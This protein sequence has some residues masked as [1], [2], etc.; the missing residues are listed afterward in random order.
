VL[1]GTKQLRVAGHKAV[2]CCRVQSSS[3]S[4][5]FPQSCTKLT[6]TCTRTGSVAGHEEALVAAMSPTP[7]AWSKPSNGETDV[8]GSVSTNA[9]QNVSKTPTTG[10]EN[11]PVDDVVTAV[12]LSDVLCL[13]GLSGSGMSATAATVELVKDSQDVVVRYVCVCVCVCVCVSKPFVKN[14]Q[15][16]CSKEVYA[17]KY[18]HTYM[19]TYINTRL[20]DGLY[21]T[22]IKH[23]HIVHTHENHIRARRHMPVNTCIH[24]CIHTFTTRLWV[25]LYH[26]YVKC[27]AC[28]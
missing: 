6:H 18:M 26:T 13:V 8:N 15:T 1:Q 27:I 24:T 4:A 7:I 22:H 3:C 20:R 16:H 21:H 12:N 23:T 10:D 14:I 28:T 11:A 19:G 25:H 2:T 5:T 9:E 17:S